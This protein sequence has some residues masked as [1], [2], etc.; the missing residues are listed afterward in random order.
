MGLMI[1]TGVLPVWDM[2]IP[3]GYDTITNNNTSGLLNNS[4]SVRVPRMGP[5]KSY[6]RLI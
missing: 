4:K 5:G 6:T 3:D 2:V 1:G